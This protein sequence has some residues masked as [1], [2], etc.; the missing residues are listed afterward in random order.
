MA[1]GQAKLPDTDA[2]HLERLR[3]AQERT[4]KV[5]SSS[6]A[7]D[8][9]APTMGMTFTV[10]LRSDTGKVDRVEWPSPDRERL[11]YAAILA[12]TFTLEKEAIYGPKVA[13]SLLRYATSKGQRVMC[14][15]VARMWADLPLNRMKTLAAS[16]VDGTPILPE[17]G[18]WDGQV[19]DRVL[20]SQLAHADDARA[21][22]DHIEEAQQQF[23][24]AGIVGDWLAVIAY[25]QAQLQQLRPDVCAS[26]T[27]WAG[28]MRTIFDRMGVTPV[29][30]K[31]RQD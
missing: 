12:R 23:S 29:L 27:P 28:S 26:V 1:R 16:L 21:V 17:D 22:L 6:V 2:G 20:Y 25:Q 14:E 8:S 19:G 13:E 15:Q 31:D 24:L 10:W 3:R 30:V 7:Q 18:I 9:D 4:V 11:A 5:L